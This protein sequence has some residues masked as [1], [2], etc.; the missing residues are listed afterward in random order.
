MRQTI[1]PPNVSYYSFTLPP[2]SNRINI[3]LVSENM[4]VVNELLGYHESN[5]NLDY[6][7]IEVYVD[8]V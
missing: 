2:T 5:I 1:L 3:I 7:N 6:F 4:H 8:I